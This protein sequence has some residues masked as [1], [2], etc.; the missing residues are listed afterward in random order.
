[1]FLELWTLGNSQ[2]RSETHHDAQR[3]ARILSSSIQTRAARDPVPAEAHRLSRITMTS[4]PKRWVMKPLTPRLEKSDLRTLLSPGAEPCSSEN[5][6]SRRQN[7]DSHT[8]S[9]DNIPVTKSSVRV[10]DGES[11]EDVVHAKQ[12]TVSEDSSTSEDWQ[13][14]TP[15]SPSSASSTDCHQGFYSFVD[16]PISP[17]AE[18]NEVYMVSPKRQAKLSTLLEKSSFKLQTYMEERRPE[19]LF[20][21]TNGDDQYYVDDVSG[22]D[23]E[24]EKPDRMEIIR[25][26]APKKNIV[27]KEQGS[28]LENLDLT[29]S[30]ESLVEGFSLC[31]SPG[32][33][34]PLQSEADP[35]TIDN[36][37]IDFNAARQQFQLMEQTK[38]NPFLRSSQESLSPKKRERSLS[39]G[40]KLFTTDF[41]KNQTPKEHP[42]KRPEN[43]VMPFEEVL[44]DTIQPSSVDHIDYGLETHGVDSSSVGH[45]STEPTMLDSIS[46]DST[47]ETPIEREI[48]IAQEREQDL[49]RSRG[50]Y[51]P[52]ASEMVEIKTKPIL[53]LPTPQI[54]PIKTKEPNRVSLLIQRENQR[55][56]ENHGLYD[57]GSRGE[58]KITFGSLSDQLDVISSRKSPSINP[59]SRSIVNPVHVE[60]RDVCDAEEPLSPCC[61]H[62]HP[63]ETM[64]EREMSAEV[65]DKSPYT[66]W[67]AEKEHYKAKTASQPFWM[68]DYKTKEP[69]KNASSPPAF[70]PEP[71]CSSRSPGVWRSFPESV[72]EWPRM[73][74][75]PDIIRREIEENL[76]RE[77]ELQKQRETKNLIS[78]A[79]SGQRSQTSLM[80]SDDSLVEAQAVLP[81]TS[82][83]RTSDSSLNSWSVDPTPVSCHSEPGSQ[84][85]LPSFT[86]AQPWS[87]P[88]HTTPVVHRVVPT[89]PS[90]PL[91][92]TSSYKGLTKTLL[93]DFEE[94]RVRLKLEESS[95]AGIQPVDDINNEVVEVTRV[96][97]HKNTR[98]L[99]WEAGVYANEENC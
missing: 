7:G 46:V 40:A 21:G 62:R 54:K 48:R 49:R 70:P 45:E 47:S 53:S 97:R 14:S 56:H 28:S 76:R 22:D 59:T 74:N 24:E 96:T 91:S 34:K 64:T 79:M 99:Q 37:Q 10:M 61:P 80:R 95:Y 92:E 12:V 89:I 57:R 27:F 25:S 63:D 19:K 36:Q 93:N 77:Q 82:T 67:K 31:F 3:Q 16:D 87:G 66:K 81:Q 84:S 98:A 38:Q 75:A 30:P 65:P 78:D 35:G 73:S 90:S 85:K 94:R 6:W 52:D 42:W 17:E 71:E 13:P 23:N 18:K 20:H 11:L 29:T 32:S 83:H 8:F 55:V 68:A 39:A 33:S 9:F 2:R 43:K 4:V 1:M 15:N 26:Q 72:S 58:R 69:R 86:K 5:S 88:K 44:E 60:Q 41:N 51:R 50:I